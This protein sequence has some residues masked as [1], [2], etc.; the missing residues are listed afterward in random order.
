[1]IVAPAFWTGGE[2]W[3]NFPFVD[4]LPGVRDL[5]LGQSLL[6]TLAKPVLSLPFD[7]P[8][9]HRTKR[10]DRVSKIDLFGCFWKDPRNLSEKIDCAYIFKPSGRV[11]FGKLVVKLN[12]K[13]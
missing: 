6:T 9:R 7:A 4:H 5:V 8:E 3:A 13:G 10:I 1:M 12:K 2:R 11:A